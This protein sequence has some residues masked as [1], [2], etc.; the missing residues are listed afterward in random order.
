[1]KYYVL[2]A[3]VTAFLVDCGASPGTKAIQANNVNDMQE[4]TKNWLTMEVS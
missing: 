1:M 4:C 3:L 2:G